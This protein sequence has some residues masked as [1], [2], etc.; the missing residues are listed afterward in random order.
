MDDQLNNTARNS[1]EQKDTNKYPASE[2]FIIPLNDDAET[3]AYNAGA[4]EVNDLL[5]ATIKKQPPKRIQEL[6][7]QAAESETTGANLQNLEEK[8]EKAE[9]RRKEYLQQKI[10]NIQ[11]TTQMLMQSDFNELGEKE[12]GAAQ[13]GDTSGNNFEG[14]TEKK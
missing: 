7:E 1:T 12:K 14:T 10:T 11:K 4:P 13:D 5:A 2:A 8:L 6:I 3:K 9:E